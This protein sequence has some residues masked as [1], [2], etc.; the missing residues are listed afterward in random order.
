MRKWKDLTKGL[1]WVTRLAI[2]AL[3]KIR[4]GD[5]EQEEIAL[6]KR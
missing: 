6:Q 3:T 2:D 1:C 4:T 5:R